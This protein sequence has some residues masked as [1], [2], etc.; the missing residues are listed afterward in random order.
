[1]RLRAKLWILKP[2]D[3]FFF[4]DG[5]P[6][7]AGE[8]GQS[9]VRG[10]FPPFMH[11]LQGAIRVTL[12]GG[13][14]WT[15]EKPERWPAELGTPDDL[16]CLRLRGPYLLCKGKTLL[17][18]PLHLLY[19]KDEKSGQL[20]FTRL[21]P[22]DE[23]ES[24][25]GV[26]RL[27]SAYPKI[28]GAKILEDAWLDSEAMGIVLGG[29]LPYNGQV[30]FPDDLWRDEHRVGIEREHSRRIA[31]EGKI[32]S[33]THVRPI[34]EKDVSL[35]VLVEG[36]PDEW[37]PE[38]LKFVR[39][40]GEGRLAMVEVDD[41]EPAL[42]GPPDLVPSGGKIYFTVTLITP[43]RYKD[44]H[45]VIKNGP[46]GLPGICVSACIGK[47]D[48]VGGWDSQGFGPRTLE[49]LIPAGSTWFF[50]AGGNEMDKVLSIHGSVIGDTYGFGQVLIGKWE[51]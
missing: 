13:R 40:G 4:R 43:G 39:L 19:K 2:V 45:W 26:I 34:P 42:P 37:H 44:L 6:Y 31:A 16:G 7:N 10:I 3:T 12:A 27:P 49:P 48:Q 22:G 17:P 1:M 32:Y 14:G 20:F 25:L 28:P 18:A 41:R 46:P 51:V 47:C 21:K 5:S 24:D 9:G 15:P 50:E 11:T 30:Y 8:G 36:V 35:A 33:C 29:G 23:V 38:D